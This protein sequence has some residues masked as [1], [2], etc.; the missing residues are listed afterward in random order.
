VKV[1][2][3][4]ESSH[5]PLNQWLQ[6]VYLMVS[7]KKGVSSYQMMRLLNCQYKTA[8]F[9]THR[10]RKAMEETG[11]G[12]RPLG[13]SGVTTEADETYVGGKAHNRAYPAV[14]TKAPV[15]A[16]VERGGRVHS[17]HVANVTADN[18]Y[19]LVAR[20]THRDS[21]FM[22]D[23]SGVYAAIGRTFK[24]GYETVNHSAKQYVRD[25]AYTNTVEGYFSILKLGVFGIYHHVSE[26]HLHRCLAEYDFRYTHR[27]ACGVEDIDR[28]KLALAASGSGRHIGQ[29]GEQGQRPSK[30]RP[31]KR[32]PRVESIQSDDRQLILPLTPRESHKKKPPGPDAG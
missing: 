12:G 15:V 26:A 14:P 25:D 8:W 32:H 21:R 7:S 28:F 13:G 16:L 29:L 6:V 4:F 2:A 19:P 3:V 17:F 30:I 11:S 9:M 20:H 27:A 5:V 10:I 18:L 1:G 22:T 23:E 31:R 24:G